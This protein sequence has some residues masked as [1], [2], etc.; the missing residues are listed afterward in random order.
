M[1]LFM[2]EKDKKIETMDE[3]DLYE[4]LDPEEMYEIIQEERNKSLRSKSKV[5]PKRPKWAFWLIAFF[6][7]ISLFSFL[8]KTFSIPILE[9]LTTSAKLSTLDFIDEYQES[10][11]VVETGD[12][13]G[14]GFSISD[15]GYILTN[16]HVIDGGSHLW[17]GYKNGSIYEA[18][19]IAAYPDMDLALL[20]VDANTQLP[21]LSLAEKT[22]FDEGEHIYFIG[23]PL[24]YNGIANEGEIIGYTQSS[25]LH[26]E[27]L[28]I[29]APIYKGNSGSPVINNKGKVIA[30]IYA[31][32]NVENYGKVGLAIP[33]DYFW[34]EEEAELVR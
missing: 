18:E 15:D 31:T 23:N 20:K 17:V 25:E 6:M 21:Y 34:E 7:I 32:T 26:R 4:E 14:T 1:L 22:L 27:V 29:D 28:M 24:N 11:V 16:E 9:F 13:K 33:I 2:D 12:S 3:T 5:K 19:V 10:I 30:V 8:P